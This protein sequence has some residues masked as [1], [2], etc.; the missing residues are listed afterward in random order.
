MFSSEYFYVRFMWQV[1]EIVD[2]AK[3]AGVRPPLAESTKLAKLP[4]PCNGNYKEL[5]STSLNP[6]KRK[7]GKGNESS[8]MGDEAV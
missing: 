7:G 5:R 3:L 2:N 4:N 6:E 8:R 1:A